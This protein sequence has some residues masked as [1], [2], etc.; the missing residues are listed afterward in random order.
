M[1]GIKAA[2]V[3]GL[4]LSASQPPPHTFNPLLH[5]MH[6]AVVQARYTSHHHHPPPH[7][8]LGYF[9]ASATSAWSEA[10]AQ[11]RKLPYC[12]SLLRYG[13]VPK[14]GAVFGRERERERELLG[15]KQKRTV[16]LKGGFLVYPAASG[17][18][19]SMLQCV[20]A[21]AEDHVLRGRCSSGLGLTVSILLAA[22]RAPSRLV[23]MRTTLFLSF[24]LVSFDL[25]LPQSHCSRR[26]CCCSPHF[27]CAQRKSPRSSTRLF[28]D[29]E[30][31]G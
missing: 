28:F 26:R 13:Y 21:C 1:C 30:D 12:R 9:F 16:E 18:F 10:A 24:N 5:S 11:H 6:H 19:V 8:A 7:R 25:S 15:V 2:I 31:A 17:I 29:V 23:M 27:T 20:W 4:H 3:Q 22:Q 14:G